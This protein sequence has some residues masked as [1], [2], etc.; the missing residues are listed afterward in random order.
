MQYSYVIATS[1]AIKLLNSDLVTCFF[2]LFRNIGV[3]TFLVGAINIFYIH[4]GCL[5]DKPLANKRKVKGFQTKKL[6]CK[7]VVTRL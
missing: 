1:F 7:L 2:L 4:F 5:N 6:K 3:N